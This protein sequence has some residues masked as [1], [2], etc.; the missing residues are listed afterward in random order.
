MNAESPSQRERLLELD[1]PSG[2]ARAA[3][4]RALQ[5]LFERRLGRFERL[6]YVLLATAGA[7]MALGLGSLAITEPATT[8]AATRAALGVLAAMGATWFFVAWRL[9]RRGSVHLISD[10]RRIAAIVFFFAVLQSGF[11][12]WHSWQNPDSIHGLYVGLV[13]LVITAVGFIVQN[14]REAELRTREQILRATLGPS[15]S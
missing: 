9:L 1:P 8:P 15:R 10:R 11:F 14:V 5:E 7:S 4:E 6:R 13:G 3:Y 12:A 2:Q